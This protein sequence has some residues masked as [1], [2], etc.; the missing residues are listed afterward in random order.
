MDL[1]NEPCPNP[2]ASQLKCVN[3]QDRTPTCELLC[4]QWNA[5]KHHGQAGSLVIFLQDCF[6]FFLNQS[7]IGS[8]VPPNLVSYLQPCDND[9]GVSPCKAS[10]I[11]WPPL[12]SPSC[13]HPGSKALCLSVLQSARM[14]DWVYLS[15]RLPAKPGSL[16]LPPPSARPAIGRLYEKP[17]NWFCIVCDKTGPSTYESCGASDVNSGSKL[18]VSKASAY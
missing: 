15:F 8:V 18:A 7:S 5:T 12:R 17:W 1:Q 14:T 9:D 13:P 4:G 16:T 6:S 11:P 3:E 2:F 10:S